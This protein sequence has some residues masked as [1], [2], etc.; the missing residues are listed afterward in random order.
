MAPDL[1][2]QGWAGE[3]ALGLC[4]L[5]KFV[6]AQPTGLLTGHRGSTDQ[7]PYWAPEPNQPGSLP[8]TVAHQSPTDRAPLL[9]TGAQL[10]TGHWSSSRPN[11]PGSFT[12]HWDPTD[13]APHRDRS[14]VIGAHS[15]AG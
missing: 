2:W 10:I 15:T 14:T 6:K 9:G 7:C 12:R 3:A 5:L 13:R 4:R 11:R 8:S 1:S